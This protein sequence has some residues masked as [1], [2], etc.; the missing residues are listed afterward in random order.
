[1]DDYGA[2][3]QRSMLADNTS[4]YNCPGIPGTAAWSEHAYG[5]AVDLN[6]FENPEVRN[7]VV[8]PPEAFAFADRTLGAQGMIIEGSAAVVAFSDIRWI[9]GGLWTEPKD[10]QHFSLTG[11]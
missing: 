6:P 9:W 1:M 4:A 7:G 10:Y 2:D 11:N 5:R 8:G 3:D